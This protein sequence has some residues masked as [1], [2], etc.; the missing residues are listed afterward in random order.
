MNKIIPFLLNFS[1]NLLI[2]PDDNFL[3]GWHERNRSGLRVETTIGLFS[4]LFLLLGS[5]DVLLLE[6]VARHLAMFG[7]SFDLRMCAVFLLEGFVVPEGVFLSW[8]ELENENFW[9]ESSKKDFSVTA[10]KIFQ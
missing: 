8:V 4:F 3:L 5:E 10:D 1:Q 7:D 6:D 9:S 2:F